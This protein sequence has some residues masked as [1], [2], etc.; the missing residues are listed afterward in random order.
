MAGL[1]FDRE[2]VRSIAKAYDNKLLDIY[3]K[4]TEMLASYGIFGN[5]NYVFRFEDVLPD[6]QVRAIFRNLQSELYGHIEEGINREWGYANAKNDI[7]TLKYLQGIDSPKIDKIRDKLFDRN[8]KALEA[9]K[10]RKRY[11][12]TLSNRVWRLTKKFKLD[13]EVAIQDIL[14]EGLADG[15]SAAELARE[16]KKHLREPDRLFRKVRDADGGL[17][18]SKQA[19]SYNPGSGVYRSSYQNALRLARTEVNQAYRYADVQRIQNLDF[20]VGIEIKRSNTY[21]DCDICENLKGRYPKD[22]EFVG[23]HPNCRCSVSTILATREEFINY[24]ETGELKSKNEITRYPKDYKGY[25]K[26]YI[27]SHTK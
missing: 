14:R 15:T 27:S 25:R 9:F 13:T 18:L 1:G 5:P 3:D 22:F 20:V 2:R 7:I 23:W 11:G 4:Y 26:D 17:R 19:K 21:Y 10:K 6:A 8:Y 24:L 16:L 12:H